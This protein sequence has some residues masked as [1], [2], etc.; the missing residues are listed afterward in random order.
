MVR[1]HPNPG[2]AP[3]PNNLQRKRGAVRTEVKKLAKLR[4]TAEQI[5]RVRDA[6]DE[7]Q[8]WLGDGEF[9]ND[10]GFSLR[11]FRKILPPKQLFVI[12][13]KLFYF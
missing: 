4:A 13:A 10:L 3:E 11:S 8:W 5:W 12:R 2:C 1:A 7:K 6:G 9:R